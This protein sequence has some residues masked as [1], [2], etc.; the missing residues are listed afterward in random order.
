MDKEERN[1]IRARCDAASE[2]PWYYPPARSA[3]IN[4]NRV[5]SKVQTKLLPESKIICEIFYDRRHTRTVTKEKA[6]ENKKFIAAARTDIPA[7]LDEVELLEQVNEIALQCLDLLAEKMDGY[8]IKALQEIY[9]LRP[10]TP[11][12]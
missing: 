3:I 11:K 4:K 2:G 6:T 1:K 10:P 7:L 12:E 9:S 8:A 5:L